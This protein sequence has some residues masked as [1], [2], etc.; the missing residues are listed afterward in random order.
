MGLREM[1]ATNS[2]LDILFSI[3]PIFRIMLEVIARLLFMGCFIVIVMLSF[4]KL[5]RRRYYFGLLTKI[6]KNMKT[7]AANLFLLWLLFKE[8]SLC[9]KKVRLIG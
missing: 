2:G 5:K 9:M 7:A 6:N 4:E 3:M 1:F 8:R